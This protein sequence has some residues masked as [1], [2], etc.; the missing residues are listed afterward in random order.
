VASLTSLDQIVLVLGYIVLVAAIIIL[1]YA[2]LI[3]TLTMVSIR[4]G[5]FYLPRLVKPGL[6]VVEGLLRSLWKAM[7]LDDRELTSFAIRLRNQMNHG[8]FCAVP[9]EQRAIF[10]PQCLRSADCP[11]D[12]TIEGLRCKRCMRCDI[13]RVIDQLEEGG[14]KV[15]IVPGSTFVRR[16]VKKYRPGAV[17]GVGCLLEVKEGL[18]M[19]DSMDMVAMGVVT[20]KDGCVET[21]MEWDKLLEVVNLVPGDPLTA[22]SLA[23]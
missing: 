11:A 6:I 17:V 23:P 5:R 4:R 16:M 13:G 20:S 18:E 19:A 2:L 7:R 1:V 15:F 3:F 21:T 22:I 8:R 10:L 14:R 9:M 12:L